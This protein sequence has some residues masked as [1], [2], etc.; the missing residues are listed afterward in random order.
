MGQIQSVA[1]S[2]SIT[3]IGTVVHMY[4]IYGSAG[5]VKRRCSLPL[6]L[7][8]YIADLPFSSLLLQVAFLIRSCDDDDDVDVWFC[9][10]SP[11]KK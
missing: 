3:I 8:I 5:G 11:D 9:V 7:P 10:A 1:S 2:K 4:Y 6:C